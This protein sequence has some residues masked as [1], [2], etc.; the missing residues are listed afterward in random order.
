MATDCDSVQNHLADLDLK[1]GTILDTD[2]KVDIILVAHL[3]KIFSEDS[4]HQNG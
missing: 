3:G 2:L 1:V 4:Q